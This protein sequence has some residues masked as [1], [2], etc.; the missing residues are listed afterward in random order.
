M[1]LTEKLLYFRS[2]ERKGIRAKNTGERIRLLLEELGPT[3]VKLGQI[4]SSRPD[5]LPPDIIKELERLQDQVRAF[6]FESRFRDH[7]ARAGKTRPR[8]VPAILRDP[9]GCGFHRS[10]LPCTA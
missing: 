9:A 1:G 10:S 4:A 5:L 8:S 3:F 7:R 6:P 2:E